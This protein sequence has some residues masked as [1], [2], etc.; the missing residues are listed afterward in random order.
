MKLFRRAF[1]AIALVSSFLFVQCSCDKDDD[2]QPTVKTTLEKISI[3]WKLTEAL[4]DGAA[5]TPVDGSLSLTQASNVATTYT[6]STGSG[7]E[8]PAG[9]A[10][11]NWS[12]NES[13]KTITFNPGDATNE[14]V[15]NLLTFDEK[16]LKFTWTVTD[17]KNNKFVYTYTYQPK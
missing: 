15:V 3:A 11:G 7:I 5:M 17:Q 9:K 13:G 10:S 14:K 16:S 2:D 1:L 4:K 8:N 6:S 12:F